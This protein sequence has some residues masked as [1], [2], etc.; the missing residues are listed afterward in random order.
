MSSFLS[1]FAIGMGGSDF[2]GSI[3]QPL[4]DRE[5]IP[6]GGSSLEETLHGVSDCES[7]SSK[8]LTVSHCVGGGTS[9]LQR[10]A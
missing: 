6:I 10:R 2:E 9:R 8:R 4:V 3:Q 7:S 1:D 5:V